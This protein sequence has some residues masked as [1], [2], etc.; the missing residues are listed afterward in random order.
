MDHPP[1]EEGHKVAIFSRSLQKDG[2]A[3]CLFSADRIQSAIFE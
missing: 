2:N 3:D 1:K